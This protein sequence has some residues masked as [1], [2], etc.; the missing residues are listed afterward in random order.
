MEFAQIKKKIEL[1]LQSYSLVSEI[2][3][4]IH[5][6]GGVIYLVGGSVRDLILELP[7]KDLD[8]E[9]HTI[10][11]QQLEAI[12]KRY[13]HVNIV[14]KAFGVLRLEHL[15]V[16]W[17]VP[18][19]DEVGRKPQVIIDSSMEVAKAFERRDLTMNAMGINL[20]TYELLDPFNGLRDIQEKILRTPN[21]A[22]FIEDPL[23]FYRVFQ[24]IARFSMKPDR[25]L[26]QLCSSMDVSQVSCERV[27][28]EAK[29][30]LLQSQKPSQS[31]QWLNALGRLEEIFPEIAQTKGV[32][33]EPD[34]HPEGDV[35]EHTL[36]TLDAAAL[37]NYATPQEKLVC[38][39]AALCHDLGKAITT[40]MREG[41]LTSY[42]HAKKGVALA[43]S[44]LKR[45]TRDKALLSSVSKLVE[46]HLFPPQFAK[47]GAKLGAYKRLACRLAPDVTLVMLAKVSTADRQGRNKER[48]T[49][50]TTKE[51][52]IDLFLLK[53]Q[54]AGVLTAPEKPLLL[55]KDLMPEIQP[56]PEMGLLVKKAYELQIK[57]NIKDKNILKN[58][59][60]GGYDK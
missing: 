4:H 40:K 17:S 15:N 44:F 18:R 27:E 58:L 33:Q 13:G 23:R 53:A 30:W 9:V 51:P 12:L 47:E 38:M 26:S 45:I 55:G 20:V 57:E 8:I 56:G 46:T 36:Q 59:V 5:K 29:K 22:R 34:W 25:V 7:V 1:L 31:L 37:L 16:D 14:G 42:E 6:E 28:L 35:F 43:R 10:S 32:L 2:V 41:R 19:I 21:P 3:A 11:L 50:L 48:G 24:F 52:L 54:E 49:P 39:Y 60:L